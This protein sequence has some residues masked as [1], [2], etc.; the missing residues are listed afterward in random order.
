MLSSRIV[1]ESRG[2][3]FGNAWPFPNDYDF[4]YREWTARGF[5]FDPHV[6]IA[7]LWQEEGENPCGIFLFSSPGAPRFEPPRS[8][9]ARG[10]LPVARC[11]GFW[12][13]TVEKQERN[14]TLPAVP[15]VHLP[16]QCGEESF[17]I[18]C[19]PFGSRVN[20][21]DSYGRPLNVRPKRRAVSHLSSLTNPTV[22]DDT[23]TLAA[24]GVRSCPLL[25]CTLPYIA[26]GP[27][28]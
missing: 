5:L 16:W 18:G 21:A 22:T 8:E 25:L 1:R 12:L 27:T 2:L 9:R 7:N 19:R 23:A 17:V 14:V 26:G 28:K 24:D 13:Y 3:Y 6:A 15:D 20:K 10:C 11:I 4:L